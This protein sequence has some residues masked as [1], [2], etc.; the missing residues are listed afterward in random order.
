MIKTAKSVIQKIKDYLSDTVFLRLIGAYCVTA[1]A[2][3]LSVLTDFT[4][5]TAYANVPLLA[6][7]VIFLAVT[8]LFT[9]IVNKTKY[10]NADRWLL[11]VSFGA[12]TALTAGQIPDM[13]FVFAF[14]CLWAVLFYYYASKGWLVVKRP[15]KKGKALIAMAVAV[16]AVVAVLCVQGVMRYRSFSSPN[17]DFGIFCNMYYRMSKDLAPLTT[18]E[19]DGLL[20]HFAV[21]VS[22]IF[23][24]LL[25]FY[26][27]FPRPETLQIAQAVI[28][29][30]AA[31]PAYL[32]ARKYRLSN[33]RAVF[34]A[35][36]LLLCPAVGNGTN[37]DFHENCF[38]LPLLLWM[39]YFFEK[40]KYVP[41]AVFG[42]LTL[43]VKEDAAI[44]IVFFALYAVLDRKK[45]ICGAASAVVALGYFAAVLL[46]LSKAG[47][48]IMTGR[49]SNY[50][51]N[52][53]GLPEAIKNVLADPAY[54]FTQ[55]F[56]DRNGVSLN[57][58]LYLLQMLAPFAFLPVAAKKPSRLLLLFPMLLINIMTVYPYQFDIGF[59]YSFG[60]T[61]FLCYAA[62]INVS[63]MKPVPAKTA[64]CT[65]LVISV[66]CFYSST[67][68]RASDYFKKYSGAPER[69]AVMEAAL[70]EIPKDSSVVCSTFLLPHL[71][72]RDE[73]YEVEYHDPA[74][75]EL[76][77]YVILDANY[78][79]DDSRREY[80][81][82]G[83][84]EEAFV[85]YRD[86]ELLI[87][88]T[89]PADAR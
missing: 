69:Y 70:D 42:V 59:Q 56:L 47:D 54:V 12:Y 28:L 26:W 19:R 57:K 32:I 6:A 10:V 13:W 60:S 65:G 21:H 79:P 84:R 33:L 80:Y 35:V 22:P 24:V 27:L 73:I 66:L 89:R 51:V 31:V 37:Y 63:E 4:D 85:S 11:P 25:P 5:L 8:L 64:L 9:L 49:F 76:P 83:Y 71:S 23:Y 74:S 41:Y 61:A 48:G 36:I 15:F 20:S 77:D 88:M 58:V 50:I 78:H 53:G 3:K 17:Y 30:S 46:W 55:L 29:G 72:D 38:L 7:G 40:E 2:I 87:I 39:F 34:C 67:Y 18:C 52:D 62:I 75:A 44:Y 43:L 82:L 68:H 45:V 86:E 16:T 1:S 81:L 14:S